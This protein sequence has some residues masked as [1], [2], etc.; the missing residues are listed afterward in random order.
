M[1]IFSNR[2]YED[3][4]TQ[5]IGA[6]AGVAHGLL[7]HYFGSKREFF[8]AVLDRRC[9]ELLER[10]AAATSD[11]SDPAR[12]LRKELD[13]ILDETVVQADEFPAL[14]GAG[15]GVDLDVRKIMLKYRRAGVDRIIAKL[16]PEPSSPFLVEALSAWTALV[17][18]MAA[19]WIE[20]GCSAPKSHVRSVLS[21]TLTATLRSVAATDKTA[22]FNPERF[23]GA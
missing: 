9:D 16:G 10:I 20:M 22:R 21:A 11:I 13:A 5:E 4:A 15:I 7:F 23:A 8:L 14:I 17:Q 18:E 12:W 3:V 19:S 2:R 6:H 1:E